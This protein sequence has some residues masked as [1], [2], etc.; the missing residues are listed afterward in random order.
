MSYLL[1]LIEKFEG[2]DMMTF[3]RLMVNDGDMGS[4][5]EVSMRT[6]S[7]NVVGVACVVKFALLAGVALRRPADGRLAMAPRGA[8]SLDNLLTASVDLLLL[9]SSSSIVKFIATSATVVVLLGVP[10][11]P[12]AHRP[13]GSISV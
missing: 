4:Q 6:A 13:P 5:S 7:S 2:G 1:S 12:S 8:L 11:T 9:P 3:G 10:D